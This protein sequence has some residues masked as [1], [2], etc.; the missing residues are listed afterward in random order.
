MIRE[1]PGGRRRRLLLLPSGSCGGLVWLRSHASWAPHAG[2]V[3]RHVR[4]KKRAAKTAWILLNFQ[5]FVKYHIKCTRSHIQSR[6]R[7][8]LEALTEVIQDASL[9]GGND[10]KTTRSQGNI[11]LSLASNWENEATW[12]QNLGT[13]PALE[14]RPKA[15]LLVAGTHE[16]QMAYEKVPH[17]C[18]LQTT[19]QADLQMQATTFLEPYKVPM[20][21]ATATFPNVQLPAASNGTA[22]HHGTMVAKFA[23]FLLAF[24]YK[25]SFQKKIFLYIINWLL[26]FASITNFRFN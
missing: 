18:C 4:G 3:S 19:M 10:A 14:Q 13:K 25:I 11:S 5:A 21:E 9:R 7:Q 6:M 26:L 16:S 24:L 12:H 1:R 17:D 2:V 22:Q 23:S 20:A 8:R 15:G